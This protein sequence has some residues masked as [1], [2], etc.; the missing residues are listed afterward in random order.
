M[1]TDKMGTHETTVLALVHVLNT[2]SVTTL[3]I[4]IPDDICISHVYALYMY[5]YVCVWINIMQDMYEY[6]WCKIGY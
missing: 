1:A 3:A 2:Y 5:V 4:I 6:L